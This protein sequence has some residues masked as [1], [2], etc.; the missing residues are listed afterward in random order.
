M[1]CNTEES[2]ELHNIV[3]ML[4]IDGFLNYLESV[5]LKTGRVCVEY[6]LRSDSS[7]TDFLLYYRKLRRQCKKHI[8]AA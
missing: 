8:Q 7:V 5:D 6:I 4:K 1:R 3:H 2:D